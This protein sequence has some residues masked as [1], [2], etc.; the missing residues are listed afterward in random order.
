MATVEEEREAA[1][2]RLRQMQMFYDKPEASQLMQQLQSRASGADS[3]YTQDVQNA[4]LAQNADAAAGQFRFERENMMR[5]FA[6][7]GLSGS[8]L[9]MS[10]M[11]NSQRRANALARQGR[12]QITSRAA[13]ANYQA[14]E[15]AQQQVQSYL[16]QIN[17]SKMAAGQAEVDFR[18]QARE[19]GDAP[20]QTT[21]GATAPTA[22]SAPRPTGNG[23]GSWFTPGITVNPTAPTIGTAQVSYGGTPT[24]NVG[25]LMP[26]W[27]SQGWSSPQQGAIMRQFGSL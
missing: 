2:Q 13:L 23:A 1:L 4:Q 12:Q 7:A 5:G 24:S 10:S 21:P 16:A 3:P 15:A 18:S 11:F 20:A 9:M 8:G 14:R 17:A 27:Q 25:T 19:V 6:N 22:P 26:A